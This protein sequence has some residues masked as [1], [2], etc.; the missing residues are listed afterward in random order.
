[1]SIPLINKKQR[2]DDVTLPSGIIVPKEIAA[3]FSP[4]TLGEL[5]P[6]HGIWFKV[7]EISERTLTLEITGQL[8][9]KARRA[10]KKKH[11]R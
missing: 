3:E 5:F 1:M 10:R 4:F 6:L 2:E 7:T 11:G 9:G 8:T